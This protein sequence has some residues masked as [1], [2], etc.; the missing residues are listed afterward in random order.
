MD[1]PVY[2]VVEMFASVQGEG[3]W[4]GEPMAFVRLA[5]CNL[6]CE[7]C[8]TDHSLRFLLHVSDIV[9]GLSTMARKSELHRVCV[10]GGEPTI[11]D[12]RPLLSELKALGWRVH[13]ETNGTRGLDINELPDW[14][15]V[16][17]KMPPDSDDL[18]QH[19]GDELKVPVTRDTTPEQVRLWTTWG[20]FRY[21]FV[22]PIAGPDFKHNVGAAIA[23]VHS[24]PGWRVSGQLHKYLGV[25]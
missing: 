24:V 20:R 7:F 14:V 12:L 9:A 5:G 3:L 2:P 21:R 10:T 17:P 25:L 13:L 1:D 15:T 16:S 23:L 6:S 22:Q 11:H 19:W 4:V 8:D 18:R